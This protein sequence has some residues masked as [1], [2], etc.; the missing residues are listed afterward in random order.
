[1]LSRLLWLAVPLCAAFFLIVALALCVVLAQGAL[2]HDIYGG[3]YVGSVPCCG[4]GEG[5]GADCEPLAYDQIHEKNGVFVIDSKRYGAPILLPSDRI[6]WGGLPGEVPGTAG[7]YCGRPR[8]S[9]AQYYGSAPTDAQPDPSFW[10]YC[11]WLN[12]GGV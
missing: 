4:G 8:S 1:M 10:T 6:Q 5:A 12:P 11:V 2:A 9:N 7:H 3:V